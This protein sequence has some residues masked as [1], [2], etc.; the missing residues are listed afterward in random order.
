MRLELTAV[1]DVAATVTSVPSQRDPSSVAATVVVVIVL[2]VE[3]SVVAELAWY[4]IC[5]QTGLAIL[6][7]VSFRMALGGK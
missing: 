3:P 7:E 2:V 6:V 1:V 5:S 4:W